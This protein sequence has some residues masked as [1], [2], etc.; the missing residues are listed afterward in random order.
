MRDTSTEDAIT[1]VSNNQRDTNTA[2]NIGI[3]IILYITLQ[4][5]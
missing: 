3:L 4:I 1:Q 5:I 2:I